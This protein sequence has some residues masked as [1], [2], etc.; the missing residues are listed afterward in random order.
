MVDPDR[1][2]SIGTREWATVNVQVGWYK[3]LFVMIDGPS[4]EL[5]KACLVRIDKLRDEH[6]RVEFESRHPDIGTGRPWPLEA[7]AD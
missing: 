5:A 6:G 1:I 7:K 2:P 4:G 3:A